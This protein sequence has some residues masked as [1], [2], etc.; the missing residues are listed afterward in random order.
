[1]TRSP[2]RWVLGLAMAGAAA[3]TE[4]ASL[5]IR[6]TFA[7]PSPAT[8]EEYPNPSQVL[9]VQLQA[10]RHLDDGTT[11]D[12]TSLAGW[13]SSRPSVG[14]VNAS[15]LFQG[16]GL[17]ETSITASYGGL[18]SDAALVR[19]GALNATGVVPV[20][21]S[22]PVISPAQATPDA[23]LKAAMLEILRRL[24]GCRLLRAPIENAINATHYHEEGVNAGGAPV[25]SG[26]E[27]T[28]YQPGGGIL[29]IG[30]TFVDGHIVIVYD[31]KYHTVFKAADAAQLRALQL[32]D[33]TGLSTAALRRALH[34][35]SHVILHTLGIDIG[36]E[37]EEQFV[38]AVERLLTAIL[39]IF[40]TPGR[41]D[42]EIWRNLVRTYFRD[43]LKK[44][45]GKAFLDALGIKDLDGDGLPDLILYAPK[46]CNGDGSGG[47]CLP[48]SRPGLTWPAAVL[49]A[50]VLAFLSAVLLKRAGRSGGPTHA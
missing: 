24:L 48:E 23:D 27:A 25:G 38:V 18:L 28:T 10:I 2:F 50:V 12:V 36:A 41:G 22:P 4:A 6:T 46:V 39:E 34:E 49:L 21:R 13:S 37:D 7:T 33:A 30:I 29:G 31:G 5:E 43:V 42:E 35:M 14:T 1:M 17:G 11:E 16:S 9:L 20:W 40:N 8:M 19:V 26:G 3:R 32:F 45:G 44:H 47:G 15:G